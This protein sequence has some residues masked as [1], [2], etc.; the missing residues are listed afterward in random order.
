MTI[1]NHSTKKIAVQRI[2]NSN[3]WLCYCVSQIC[4]TAFLLGYVKNHKIIL[5]NYRLKSSVSIKTQF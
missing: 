5:G 1:E 3:W 2:Y 4:L